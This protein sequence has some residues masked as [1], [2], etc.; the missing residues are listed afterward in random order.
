MMKVARRAG[1][2]RRALDE[3]SSSQCNE[4]LQIQTCLILQ[5]FIK[6]L[7]SIYQA[8]IKPARC[9]LGICLMNARRA[10][11]CNLC[12]ITLKPT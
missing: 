11:H 9:A 7:S 6:H 10:V 12:T 8:L 5:T 3:R 2:D 1:V 4:Y